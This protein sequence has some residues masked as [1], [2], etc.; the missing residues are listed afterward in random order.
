MLQHLPEDVAVLEAVGCLFPVAA[1]FAVVA[2]LLRVV[3]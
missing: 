2:A 1:A 3:L